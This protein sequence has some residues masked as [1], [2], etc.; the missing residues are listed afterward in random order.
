MTKIKKNDFVEIEYTGKIA[1]GDIIF[2]TTDEAVAKKNDLYQEGAAYGPITI[3]IGE[4]HLIKGLDAKLEG[5]EDEKS[6][7]FTLSPEEG[8]GKKS[9]KLFKLVPLSV[10]RKQNVNPMPGLQVNIDGVVGTIKNATGGRVIVDFNHPLASREL[11]YD[12][13]VN[14]IVTKK[15]EKVA[16]LIKLLFGQEPKI[17]MKE[18]VAEIEFEA[19]LPAE[20]QKELEKKLIE[21]ADIKKAVFKVATKKVAEKASNE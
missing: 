6:Y 9:A 2:D 4:K 1:E 13:K 3:C 21:L 16:A 5:E 17:T 18:D 14:K 7:T 19:E 10:F 8:F 11:I 20:L 12:I 15:E